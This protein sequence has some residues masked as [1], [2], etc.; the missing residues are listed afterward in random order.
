M[1]REAGFL[2]TGAPLGSDVTLIAQIVLYAMLCLGIVA[3]MRR[4]YQWHDRLQTTVVLANFFFIIFIM[5]F[6]FS[7][8]QVAATLPQRPRD[9]YYLSPA[10]HGMVGLIAQGL[11]TYA[12]LAGHRILPRR[13]GR[14]RYW[15][16]ATFFF[17]TVAFVLG[18]GTYYTWYV[19]QGEPVAAVT[20]PRGGSGVQQALLQNFTFVP[21]DLTVVAGTR[22]VW[23]NQ[24]AAPHNVT[25]DDGRGSDNFFQGETFTF[26][27]DQLGEFS[28][29][30][31]LHGNPGSGMAG[32]VRVVAAAEPGSVSALPA[33]TP[34]PLPLPPTPTPAPALPPPPLAPL[35]PLAPTQ[36]LVGL[37][38]FMDS[39]APGDTAVLDL[40]GIDSPAPG[41]TLVAWLTGPGDALLEIGRIT[42]NAAGK[43]FHTYTHPEQQNLMA[44]YDGVQISVE[45]GE[46]A[47]AG[48]GTVLY[49]GRQAAQ[50]LEAM[51]AI[52]VQAA[53]PGE[54]GLAVAARL[55]AEELLRH[56]SFVQLAYEL[57]SIADAQRHAE[58]IIN[59]LEGEQ[60]PYFGD[61]D[62]KHGI[63]NP[64]DGFG[65]MAYLEA[66]DQAAQQAA[67][68]PDA[69][70]AIRLHAKHVS[71]ATANGR[72]WAVAVRQAALEITELQRIGEIG[73]QVA[74]LNEYGQLLLFGQKEH[75]HVG[76]GEVPPENGG[77]LTAYQHAQYMAAIPI[78][79]PR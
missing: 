25:F 68:A 16:W 13:I 48:P 44:V 40:S 5:L 15:M 73:P 31:T 71:I 61:H 53:V 70:D 24:D 23:L 9:P 3:Q 65:L 52:T 14:L 75:A 77:I 29:Y 18:I 32:R 17:W 39:Y 66:M 47:N 10:V 67:A 7:Q 1:L 76:Y 19:R 12:L 62:G 26:T 20:V 78:T 51:R 6:A 28:L 55:Q 56:V 45:V 2:G 57:L 63:Q 11:A 43:V 54:L 4:A 37:V 42:P 21:V 22:V 59:I 34:T 41:Y 69:T 72:A 8:Q 74:G 79:T 64:G 60:G 35:Q 33:T 30:C 50:A 27:F 49:S 58:H 38:A 36:Q 46:G